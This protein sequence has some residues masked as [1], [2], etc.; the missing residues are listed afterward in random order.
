VEARDHR[1]GQSFGRTCPRHH[2]HQLGF[3]RRT[4]SGTTSS[5]LP[6][7]QHRIPT[8]NGRINPSCASES[9]PERPEILR[10][11][12]RRRFG[13]R[14]RTRSD[15]CEHA[16]LGNGESRGDYEYCRRRQ[17]HP[18]VVDPA[19]AG[20]AATARAHQSSPTTICTSMWDKRDGGTEHRLRMLN[21][22]SRRRRWTAA[23][24]YETNFG[25]GNFQ[26]KPRRPDSY[27]SF[28]RTST[29]RPRLDVHRVPRRKRDRKWRTPPLELR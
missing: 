21:R 18:E 10:H 29:G 8:S 15:H 1:S 25:I 19:Q 9:V 2:R 5:W 14:P 13:K 28:E 4:T 6:T 7:A 3:F 12:R 11:L 17:G 24:K 27:A 22:P 16:A 20:P 26:D 23:L